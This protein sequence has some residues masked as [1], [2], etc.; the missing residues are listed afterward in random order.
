MNMYSLYLIHEICM[1]YTGYVISIICT[2]VDSFK[3]IL[4][5][6]LIW[7]VNIGKTDMKMPVLQTNSQKWDWEKPHINQVVL[8]NLKISFLSLG[9][10]VIWPKTH[11]HIQTPTHMHMWCESL[12]LKLKSNFLFLKRDI[13]NNFK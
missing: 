6:H 12:S 9:L 11:T 8:S 10:Q 2:T 1:H 5:S 3:Y 4:T 13:L 7:L